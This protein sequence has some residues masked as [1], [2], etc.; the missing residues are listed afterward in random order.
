MTMADERYRAI[1]QARELLTE[2]AQQR[3]IDLEEIRRQ[4]QFVLRHYPDKTALDL[5]AMD[6]NPIPRLSPALGNM[7]W[8][9][10]ERK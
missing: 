4:A 3:I 7:L 5:I 1:T 8:P 10:A 2:I 6:L 9:P